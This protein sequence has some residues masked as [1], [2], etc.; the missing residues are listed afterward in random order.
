MSVL[1][2]ILRGVISRYHVIHFSTNISTPK[3]EKY[4]TVFESKMYKFMLLFTTCLSFHLCNETELSIVLPRSVDIINRLQTS[5]Q[6]LDYKTRISTMY[7]FYH[8]LIL[9]LLIEN[10]HGPCGLF[11][12]W[13]Q[14]CA[15]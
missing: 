11:V 5:T 8:E 10:T 4:K 9:R 13:Y 14:N 2:E 7:R 12:M 6:V 1:S 15:P 3:S